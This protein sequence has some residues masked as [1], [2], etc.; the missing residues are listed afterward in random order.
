MSGVSITRREFTD[1]ATAAMAAIPH[2]YG[3]IHARPVNEGRCKSSV[4]PWARWQRCLLQQGHEG[5]CICLRETGPP[6]L[7]IPDSGKAA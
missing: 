1:R 2:T 6:V 7:T 5:E 3:R 4:G